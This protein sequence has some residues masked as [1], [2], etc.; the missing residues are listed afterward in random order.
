M[1]D[2]SHQTVGIA[3]LG[4]IGRAVFDALNKGIPG[5]TLAA[6]SEPAPKFDPGVPNMSFADLAKTC[7]L[8]I[9]CLPPQHV[10]A[11]ALEVFKYG[12]NMV[13]ISSS[14]LLMFPEILAQH[15][16]SDSRIFVPSGALIGIDGVTALRHLGIKSAKIATTK[17]PMGYDGAPYIVSHKIDL[18]AI[19]E[20]TKLFTGNAREAS[21]AFP[22]NVNVAATL[23]LAG[24]GPENTQVE[25]W[26][27]PEIGGNTHEIEVQSEFSTMHARVENRPDPAN[28]KSSMLAAQS[29][30][31]MLHG[32]SAP[33]VVL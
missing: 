25:I 6:V 21:A 33:L 11:L 26:A 12:K 14:A 9:E 22:A 30:I 24:I 17:K 20:K 5:F 13:V 1:I 27:D 32:M 4:A 15:Q 28:P 29:I 16:A 7:D 3:G 2:G 10:P 23:S 8:I 18:A 31:A 19:K